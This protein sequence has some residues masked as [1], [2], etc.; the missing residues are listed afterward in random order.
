[1][2]YEILD[3]R[4]GKSKDT[5]NCLALVL[6]ALSTCYMKVEFHALHFHRST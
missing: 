2:R 1:M 3:I 6:M 5:T 4:Y